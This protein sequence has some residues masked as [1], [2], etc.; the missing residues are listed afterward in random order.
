MMEMR[1]KLFVIIGCLLVIVACAAHHYNFPIQ[2][3]Q[4]PPGGL[5]AE[6]VPMFVS[7]GTDDNPHSGLEGSGGGGG[8]HYLTE[9]FGARKNADGTPLHYSFYVNTKY[10]TAEGMEDPNLVKQS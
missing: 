8:M 7:F 6:Q 5:T 10:I 4:M 9:L 3:M 2:Q 1:S